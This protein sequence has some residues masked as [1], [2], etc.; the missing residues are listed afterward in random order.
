M[1]NILLGSSLTRIFNEIQSVIPEGLDTATHDSVNIEVK[2][3][4][5]EANEFLKEFL[6]DVSSKLNLAEHSL[7]LKMGRYA[8]HG[9]YKPHVWGAFIPDV[10]K[11]PSHTTPQL[12]L[13]RSGER[14]GWGICPSDKAGKDLK[15]MEVYRKI[16]R[17]NEST[18]QQLFSAGFVGRAD[19][20]MPDQ[21]TS[22]EFFK[23]ERLILERQ[24]KIPNMPKD[25]EFESQVVSDFKLLIP[26]YVAIVDACTMSGLVERTS[27]AEVVEIA[28]RWDEWFYGANEDAT[29][30]VPEYLQKELGKKW[31]DFA[32]VWEIGRRESLKAIGL[33]ERKKPIPEDLANALLFGRLRRTAFTGAWRSAVRD[34][35]P[36][37]LRTISKFASE[38]PSG[39]KEVQFDELMTEIQKIC[40][41]KA[42]S[43]VTRI[44]CDIAPKA[45][46]PVSNF[47]VGALAKFASMKGESVSPELNNKS[48]EAICAEAKRLAPLAP[49]MPSETLLYVFDHF[50]YWINRDE[51]GRF[52]KSHE[53]DV[54]DSPP[55]FWKISCGEGGKHASLHR[56]TGFIS[57]GWGG[58][59]DPRP[60]PDF[61]DYFDDF[62]KQ[63]GVEARGSSAS[64]TW[65]FCHSIKK[66][67][68]ILGYGSGAILQIGVDEGAYD[69]RDPADW[70]GKDSGIDHKHIRKVR[71]LN[72]EPLE[73]NLFSEATQ[74]WLTRRFTIVKLKPEIADEIRRVTGDFEELE[75]DQ[76][77]ASLGISELREKTGKSDEFINTVARRL[78]SKRQLVFA[79][80]PGTSKTHFAKLFTQ[81]FA[82]GGVVET[83]QFHP[84]YSY[85]DF[86]EGFRPS[87]S[88]DRG[89]EVVP[90]V[91]KKFCT[92]ARASDKKHVLLIDEMNR[93]NLA[94]IFGELL[95]LLEYRDDE[96]KLPYS[97]RGFS[98]PKN[99][100]IVATMNSADRSIAM[101][102]FALR[103]RFEF[104]EFPADANSLDS[105]LRST[106][107]KVPI[108]EVVNLF[109][110]LNSV[111]TER[112]GKG[113]QVG[114]TYFMRK[115]LTQVELQDVWAYSVMPLLEEYF[116]DDRK[117]LES[118]NFDTLWKRNQKAA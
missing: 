11:A 111:V 29:K 96:I 3:Q 112:L 40:G 19:G 56:K 117:T 73:T 84:S 46:L 99:V 118:L 27:K 83:I 95:Q 81:W 58:V 100:Y 59:L 20:E 114:H 107:C 75:Y 102:D 87:E 63:P 79:G 34:N 18:L 42:E 64:Q 26:I 33:A 82:E 38:N 32:Q 104:I 92:S 17:D 5:K 72:L 113:Y 36:E 49:D 57:V 41:Y 105:F 54:Q 74:S 94:Q 55:T 89:F 28:D 77:Q 39:S 101:L 61:N 110:S 30:D 37:L 98:I 97:K 62:T 15:F 6:T 51:V 24:Y 10:V 109:N 9:R 106:E 14:L 25:S 53:A 80:P 13:L 43:F 66:G 21:F 71:W 85:E 70:A 45:Y 60:Y 91:F 7:H 44:L 2:Q 1:A 78:E 108:D 8:P 22:S 67:D 65:H 68:I 90:G 12:Y 103:R 116:Y 50:L 23:S 69:F 35:L 76:P 47:T 48:Y 93:G 4:L 88:K 52:D 86:I 31:R 16:L 115:G